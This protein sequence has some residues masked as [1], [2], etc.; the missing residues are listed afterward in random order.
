V[1]EIPAYCDPRSWQP[2]LPGDVHYKPIIYHINSHLNKEDIPPE[3]TYKVGL[4]IPDGSLQLKY[5]SKYAIR[6][7]N[8]I[9]WSVDSDKRYGINILGKIDIE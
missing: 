9:E 2:Y 6:C 1:K 3:G 8:D 4:W 5:N 7:A